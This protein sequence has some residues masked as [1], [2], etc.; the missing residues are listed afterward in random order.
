M[1]IFAETSG[2]AMFLPLA[3][4]QA[5]PLVFLTIVYGTRLI[6]FCTAS[7][8]YF[9]PIN[10]LIAYKVFEGL[11]TA[12]LLADCPTRVSLSSVKATY[13]GVVLSPSLFSITFV[14][15]PSMM[16]THEFVVPKSIPIIA[17]VYLP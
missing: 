1:S 9:L 13:D 7:S 15:S 12:C 14:L 4:T 17:T 11:V 10:L 6:S 5:S 2:G 16:E 3:S 8:S